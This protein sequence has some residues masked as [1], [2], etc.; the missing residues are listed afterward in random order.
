MNDPTV[1]NFYVLTSNELNDYV[2]DLEDYIQQLE[3]EKLELNEEIRHLRSS[4]V[5]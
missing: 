4:G 1:K 2:R 3:H 5:L